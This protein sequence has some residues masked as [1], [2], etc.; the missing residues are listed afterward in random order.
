MIC[1][2]TNNSGNSHDWPGWSMDPQ[3]DHQ[4]FTVSQTE[5]FDVQPFLTRLITRQRGMMGNCHD[6]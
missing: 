6:L 3:V 4:T 1:L 5:F 2:V